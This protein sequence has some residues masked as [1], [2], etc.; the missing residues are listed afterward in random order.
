MRLK[1]FEK[2]NEKVE[3]RVYFHV[4]SEKVERF[5]FRIPRFSLR[6]QFPRINRIQI[7]KLTNLRNNQLIFQVLRQS[8]HGELKKCGNLDLNTF[9][10]I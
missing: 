9:P 8:N 5:E 10:S 1:N 2:V 6:I 4:E 3:N 7:L